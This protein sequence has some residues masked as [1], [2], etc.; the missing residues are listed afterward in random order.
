MLPWVLS[1]LLPTILAAGL[2]CPL[3]YDYA[4]VPHAGDD[5]DLDP[6]LYHPRFHLM[7]PTRQH[8]PTG[9]NDMNAM[10]FHEG[11]YHVTYQDHIDC[12]DDVNQANQ[13]FGHVVSRD[14]V[15]W[16]HLP[17][18][19]VDV[20]NFDGRLGPWDG[21]GFVCNGTPMIIYNSHAEGPS[22]NRQTKTG[23]FPA[24]P[25]ATDPLLTKWVHQ[26]LSPADAFIGPSTLAPPWKGADGAYYTSAYNTTIRKCQLWRTVD[27]TNCTAWSIVSSNFSF[28]A[29]NSPELY[30]T[31]PPCD[32]G[33]PPGPPPQKYTMV[34]KQCM[35]ETDGY[36]FGYTEGENSNYNFVSTTT[37]QFFEPSKRSQFEDGRSAWTESL[38][39]PI[40]SRRVMVGWVPP[41]V[42]PA[43][44]KPFPDFPP[45]WHMCSTLRDV[46]FDERFGQLTS[47][48]I[49][50]Y[51][52]LRVPGT[53]ATIAN[54][55]LPQG[56]DGVL[57][58][59]GGRQLDINVSFTLPATPGVRVGVSVLA[60]TDG[61]TATDIYIERAPTPAP[62]PVSPY[63][64]HTDL[65]GDDYHYF[66]VNYSQPQLCA[67]A[68]MDDPRCLA[69]TYVGVSAATNTNINGSVYDADGY[70]VPRCC[71][72]N[73]VPTPR[74]NPSCTS[75][76]IHP[77]PTPTYAFFTLTINTTSSG[78]I[79]DHTNKF[80]TAT[81]AFR[82]LASEVS[83]GALR[84]RVVVDR[85]IVEAFAMGGRAVVTATAYAPAEAK[86][87]M[88]WARNAIT[89]GDGGGDGGVIV[90]NATSWGMG[91]TWKEKI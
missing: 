72:K 13:S 74:P 67:K 71:F 82:V 75:G 65:P 77:A 80:P 45:L 53:L 3:G 11:V 4:G 57:L 16:Q 52:R 22:F 48:P 46:R 40:G 14:L 55:Q 6:L 66:G 12:P 18:A 38:W 61:Q 19:L 73:P 26:A 33:C 7:P 43:Y 64:P 24:V 34:A 90:A 87:V 2:D 50:E 62:S 28:C 17:P 42:S 27:N 41:G 76:V 68:C 44:T 84:L 83:A 20:P 86:S 49:R 25:S 35:G 29:N 32:D 31:P 59:S 89:G 9:M 54:K 30:E 23:A 58:G 1:T 36:T 81:K 88:L 85:S 47:F 10:F 56:G 5:S 60:T 37:M 8:M 91:C 15:S 21:P 69:W 63:M 79:P 70:P 78:K 39:D 51:E